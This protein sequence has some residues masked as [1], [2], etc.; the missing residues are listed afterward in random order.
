M[1]EEE[2]QRRF[3]ALPPIE[4]QR[5]TNL[6]K[7]LQAGHPL[8]EPLLEGFPKESIELLRDMIADKEW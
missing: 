7:F 3:E 5:L 2:Y 1:K 4:Q 8:T 6:I